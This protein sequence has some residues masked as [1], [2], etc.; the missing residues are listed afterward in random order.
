MNLIAGFLET[1]ERHGSR[2]AII[3]GNGET[4]S[5][6]DLA[7]RS[8]ALAQGWHRAGLRQGDRVLVAMSVGIDLYASIAALWRVGATIVFPEPALGLA[9]LRHAV[10]LTRPRALLTSGAYGLIRLVLPELWGVGL[11]LGL[12]TGS[13]GDLLTAST[14]D[15]PALISFTS[16]S[17]GKPKAIVRSHGFLA[18]QDAALD[19]LIAPERE[20]EVDLVAFPVFVL[21]NLARGTTSALPNWS[22]RDPG[23]ADIGSILRL[24]EKHRVTRALVPPSIGDV[25][26]RAPA[27]PLQTVLTGGGPV[28][29]DLLRRL[30]RVMPKSGDTI[31]V[32]GSTEAEPIAWQR[33]SDISPSQWQ[34][35]EAGS[36]LL[37]GRPIGAVKVRLISDEI[38]VTGD[39]VNKSYLGG[40]GDA[41]NK[42]ALEGAIWHRT[43]DA[44]RLDGEG[45][46]WLKGRLS[47]LCSG[48]YPFEVEV[49]ARLWPGVDRTALVSIDGRPVLAIEGD[50]AQLG[51]W[52]EAGSGICVDAV[53]RVEHM[54][55]DRRHQ[56]KIDHST[57][58]KVMRRTLR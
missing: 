18:A 10:R 12:D 49:P 56:S 42:I 19:P 23:S 47:G 51:A 2:T 3:A 15:H 36:G 5:F 11:H 28:F 6:A 20:D 4:I 34:A 53:V 13:P 45:L 58:R 16:G 41:D 21:A 8:G 39:H 48:V 24:L 30:Q 55:M 1:A 44:G 22:L 31:S 57:L 14:P 25:L 27:L 26:A 54:P 33:A 46:L 29:P 32:Y 38:V 9:G 43:G 37:A 50:E 52:K 17:T 35:M 7:R 40:Q